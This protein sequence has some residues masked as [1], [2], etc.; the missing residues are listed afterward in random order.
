MQF[1]STRAGISG[2][3]FVAGAFL[4]VSVVIADISVGNSRTNVSNDVIYSEVTL[5][6]PSGVV[7]GDLLLASISINGGQPTTATTTHP[8]GWTLL[9]KTD[10][11]THVGI[12]TYW[13]IAG[14][15]EPS[16]YT[17]TIGTQVRAVGGITRFTGVSTSNPIDVVASS[18]GRG[19]SAIAPSATTTQ[20]GARIITVFAVNVGKENTIFATST[21]MTKLYDIKN[22]PLGPTAS[23]QERSQA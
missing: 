21:G 5:T 17:W 1:L 11:D 16:S 14:A 2:S 7:S 6:K 13:K 23:A 18:T 15:S 9:A 12:L 4:I 8:S 10:N 22:E 20:D 3:I 19:T